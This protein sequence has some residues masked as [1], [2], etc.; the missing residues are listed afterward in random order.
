MTVT[1][2]KWVKDLDIGDGP[3]GEYRLEVLEQNPS[4]SWNVVKRYSVV[5][6]DRVIET[7]TGLDVDA[8]YS[9]RVSVVR[10]DESGKLMTDWTPGF[11][12]PFYPTQCIV[13]T[14][15][16]LRPPTPA[17]TPPPGSLFQSFSVN[18]DAVNNV[19]SV[20]WAGKDFDNLGNVTITYGIIGIGDCGDL[21]L[22][23][24]GTRVVER[25][26]SISVQ[27]LKPY[28]RYNVKA[29]IEVF[30]LTSTE[31]DR[32]IS[33]NITT[34]DERPRGIVQN[35]GVIGFNATSLTLEWEPPLCEDRG[36]SLLEYPYTLSGTGLNDINGTV[37]RGR[38]TISGLTPYSSYTFGVSYRNSVGDGPQTYLTVRT[39]EAEPAAPVI[40]TISPG[41][42]SIEVGYT[43][44]IPSNGIIR[45]YEVSFS[46]T[47]DFKDFTHKSSA[48][49]SVTVSSLTPYTNYYIKVRART[50]PGLWGNF[51][52]VNQTQTR[53]AIPGPPSNVTVI[54][55]NE[56]CLRISWAPPV[57]L[58][59]VI[60]S[61]RITS[62]ATDGTL[63]IDFK[64]IV[65]PES[66]GTSHDQ[67]ALLV[68]TQYK[69]EVS[70][71]SNE[72][73][74]D[75]A[76]AFA[77]TYQGDP[78]TPPAPQ[79]KNTTESTIT[80]EIYPFKIDTG[81]L[82]AYQIYVHELPASSRR[83]RQQAAGPPGVVVAKFADSDI[84]TSRI[85]VVGDGNVYG[86]KSN[87]PLKKNTKYDIYYE[88]VS[89]V[90]TK[91]K[92]NYSKMS[93]TATTV[94]IVTT[95]VPPVVVPVATASDNTPVI[96]AVVIILLILLLVAIILLILF[97]RSRINRFSP[98]LYDT[99]EEEKK[100]QLT[101]IDE[102]N[103]HEHWNTIYSLRESRYIISGR[104]LVPDDGYHGTILNGSIPVNMSSA[105][106]TF[107]QEFHEL[108]HQPL[109]PWNDA[110]RNKNTR[111]NRFRH[112]LPYDHTRV[113]LDPDENSNGDFINANFVKGYNKPHG[114]IAAQSP[115]DEETVL[116]F[117]RMLFQYNV[118]VVVMITNV[119]EDKIVKC[120]KYWPDSEMGKVQYGSFTLALIDEKEYADFVIRSVKIKTKHDAHTKVVHIFDFCSWPDHGVPDD[121]IPLLEFRHKVREYHGNDKSPLVVHCGTGVS[122][123]GTFIAI[124]ALI[125]QYEAE[126]IISVY[127]F[128]RRMRKDRIAMVRTVKQYIFIYEAIFE[129]RVAGDTRAGSDLKEK[130]H[131]LTM[132]NPKTKHS[133]LRDQFK[134]LQL[135]TRKPT[136]KQ[137]SVS[138]LPMNYSKNRFP[139]VVPP[140]DYRPILK[141]PGGFERTDYINAVFLDSHELNSHFIVTQS[142]LHTT[143]IDFWKLV[144]DH[145]VQ[146]IVMMEDFQSEDDT[147]AEYWPEDKI[148]K[149]EPFFVD[150]T[151]IWQQENVTIRHFKLHNMLRVKST[152]REVRQFQFNAWSENDFV[153]KSKT[154]FLDLID[155]VRSWQRQS[156]EN[157]APIVVHCK[158]G[159]TH[160]GL[161]C[162][163]WT[164]CEAMQM[165]HD[166]DVYHNVKH[167]KKRRPQIVDTL[168]QYRFC[169]KVLWD[170]MNLRMPGG[171]L[172]NMMNHTK[173]DRLYNVGSLSLASYTSHL[174]YM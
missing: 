93:A 124:D 81:P 130:Y 171:T 62:S 168:D 96:V 102:Y 117:W 119:V 6:T 46:I 1:F 113:V 148:K 94:L 135:F 106:V 86:G 83:R 25:S 164:I 77:R 149:F 107:Q 153:P 42:T 21:N 150:N 56:T 136:K 41:V 26:G 111:K 95:V 162:A 103:P 49:N 69:V 66:E 50:K 22:T 141:T 129:A 32:T 163:V 90:G 78:E 17:P 132:R 51:S 104:D 13:P 23:V 123:T 74:G 54:P 84:K 2:H 114:Y 18:Y 75:P 160:S 169:Y 127:S 24:E 116:D 122:R 87:P 71:S 79:L 85:F 167:M 110:V 9:F 12:S 61:Y 134:S 159:A 121:P 57:F 19:L 142:P 44:P 37:R 133:F 10:A 158:D 68:Y 3:I 91:T 166:V 35:V 15:T 92:T 20:T 8:L 55:H 157:T 65:K 137:C 145:K 112:L 43:V 34:Q 28:R 53:Q 64:T 4:A 98:P 105:P 172:T 31:N 170:Y 125:D 27:G 70:A 30:N 63:V 173:Q 38:V 97:L 5:N 144:Y 126:G 47:P 88:I 76:I 147:T 156:N 80:I 146:T 39:D 155:L 48:D 67:C 16:T 101:A 33:Q 52:D 138:H 11:R 152:P 82:T 174:E 73:T 72:G 120:S 161:F 118:K 36:G 139:D 60:N 45:E 140:N 99:F 7:F 108:P 109:A 89:T 59:G 100:V 143:V 29:V 40:N 58:G 151:N 154:M 131:T 115:F 165:D 14:T 128:V